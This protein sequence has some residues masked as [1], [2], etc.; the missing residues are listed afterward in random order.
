MVAMFRDHVDELQGNTKY[1]LI[2]SRKAP[3]LDEPD[4]CSHA[5]RK[6]DKT[7]AGE[8]AIHVVA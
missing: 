4:D 6:N 8:K 7:R 1:R 2:G 5:D 3:L